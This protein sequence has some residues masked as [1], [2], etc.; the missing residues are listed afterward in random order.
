MSGLSIT[1]FLYTLRKLN[2][3][4]FL[5]KQKIK[6]HSWFQINCN[7]HLLKSQSIIKYLG[8]DI[9]QHLSCQITISTPLLKVNSRLRC[10]YRKANWGYICWN[11]KNFKYDTHTMLFYLVLFLLIWWYICSFK[12]TSYKWHRS[13]HFAILN[14]WAQ[15]QTESKKNYLV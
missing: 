10:M 6:N 8:N 13:K 1:I 14:I 2:E 4:Y 9:E 7:C 12:I 11:K 5:P 3:L 15:E